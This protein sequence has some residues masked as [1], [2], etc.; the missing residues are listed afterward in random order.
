[1][2]VLL[3]MLMAIILYSMRVCSHNCFYED[4]ISIQKSN[5][6]KGIFALIIMF[7]HSLDYFPLNEGDLWL[8][9][10]SVYLKQLIVV[11][12]LFYSGF[13][14]MESIQKKGLFY[15][16]RIPVHNALKTLIWADLSV[17]LYTLYYIASGRSVSL[18]RFALSLVFWDY[19]ENAAWY[20]F[21]I[22]VLYLVT[23][24][25]FRIFYRNYYIAAVFMLLLSVIPFAL[26]IRTKD[27]FWYNTFFIFHFG[28]WYSLL[29]IHIE[30]MVMY[31]DL[32]YLIALLL[33]FFGFAIFRRFGS[34]YFFIIC[35]CF[36]CMTIVGLTMKVSINN[37]ILQFLGRHVFGFYVFQRLPMRI[38]STMQLESWEKCIISILAT[39][40]LSVGFDYV[41][42]W[43]DKVVF[44]KLN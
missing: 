37:E 29:R 33:A 14:I 35:G 25:S 24:I 15:I 28:M 7:C 12:I 27:I 4:Y 40:A 32:A 38:V 21:V 36:F 3:L 31:N 11:P 1:M 9:K 17:A 6:I 39:A 43:L 2:N 30:K 8:G 22:I 26:L 18:K 19:I 13:G 5:A 20:F 23:Y 10:M 16:K 42:N 34:F 41:A 44:S